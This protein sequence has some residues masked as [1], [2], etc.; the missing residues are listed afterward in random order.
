MRGRACNRAFGAGR[1]HARDGTA[2]T[3]VCTP[4][5]AGPGGLATPGVS[6]RSLCPKSSP[7]VGFRNVR[8]TAETPFHMILGARP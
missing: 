3:M 5:L 7:R 6:R 1:D 4:T 2:S 8:R